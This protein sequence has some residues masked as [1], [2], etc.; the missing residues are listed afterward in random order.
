M[1]NVRSKNQTGP[2]GRCRQQAF[3]WASWLHNAHQA[4]G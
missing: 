1:S 2:D 3:L 4:L